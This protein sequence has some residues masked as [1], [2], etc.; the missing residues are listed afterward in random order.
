MEGMTDDC[1]C[2]G[3]VGQGWKSGSFCLAPS[4]SPEPASF[5]PFDSLSGSSHSLLETKLAQIT[6]QLACRAVGT[7]RAWVEKVEAGW[8]IYLSV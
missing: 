6:G 8:T 3:R 5:L 4:P 1:H 2:Q 7:P